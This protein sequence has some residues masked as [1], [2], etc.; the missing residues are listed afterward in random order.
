[1]RT[2]RAIRRL[3][4][5]IVALLVLAPATASAAQPEFYTRYDDVTIDDPFLT[6]AC[7]FPVVAHFEGAVKGRNFYDKEG[8]LVRS[9]ETYSH[10]YLHTFT[11]LATGTSFTSSA[12]AVFRYEYHE[13][14]SI[15]T[16]TVTGLQDNITVPGEGSVFHDA[17]KIVIEGG[18]ITFEAGR[19]DEFRLF[20]LDETQQ[21]QE[22]CE[23]LAA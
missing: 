3:L 16:F 4:L 7:G 17:G 2:L 8:N 1:M 13:D 5:A 21:V 11:N 14:G 22:L 15:R 12:P 20:L 18:E 9:F 10:R 19:H 23:A 6:P